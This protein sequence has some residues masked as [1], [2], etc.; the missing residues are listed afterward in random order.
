M[1]Y[2]GVRLLARAAARGTGRAA[3]EIVLADA[4]QDLMKGDGQGPVDNYV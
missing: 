3:Y 4:K 1:A 2:A